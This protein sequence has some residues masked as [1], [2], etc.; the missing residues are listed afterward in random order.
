MQ[1]A[2]LRVIFHLKH[3]KN[4]HFLRFYPDFQFLVE[5]KMAPKITTIVDDVTV[6]PP[7][8]DTI[9]GFPLKV[10]SFRHTATYQKL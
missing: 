7:G 10:K 1:R 3:K 6:P 2:Y 5:S 4:R 9:K 8:S